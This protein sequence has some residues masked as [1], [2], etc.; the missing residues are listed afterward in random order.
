VTDFVVSQFS[1]DGSFV[2][3][4]R[5]I[6]D[7]LEINHSDWMQNI[8][9]KYQ[10]QTEQSFGS[11]RFDN[12]VKKRDVGA[13]VEK[14]VWLTE[15][16]A[17]FYI[18]LSKN[19][20]KVV[21]C[22]ANLVRA[23][24]AYRQALRRSGVL[25]QPHSTVYI[26]RLENMADHKV[27]DDLW[28]TFREAAEILL[29]VEKQYKV[30]VNQLDLCDG[31]VGSRWRNYRLTRDDNGKSKSWLCEVGEY[32]HK[33]RDQRGE[34]ICNAYKYSEIPY[35]KAWL[36]EWYMPIHLPE[37]LVE[38]YGKRAVRQ[39]Y[40]EQGLLNDY[41]MQITEE[42]RITPKQDEMYDLF[43]AARE[44]IANRYLLE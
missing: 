12:E 34:R 31:S 4:S 20:P 16:Q 42:K 32:I 6:A 2:I 5:L 39:I 1:D 25:V 9:K 13:T 24:I 36:R 10:I 40:E 26:K 3:D 17:L 7:Y 35:F 23:F 14:F 33:F 44:A 29:L 22:K 27:P 43:L 19:S 37:Y 8:I 30:P 18:T 28:T 21:E 41:I 38:K 15:E 11:L